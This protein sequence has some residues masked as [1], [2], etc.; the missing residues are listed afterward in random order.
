MWPSLTDISFTKGR[1]ATD[2]DVNA[3]AAVFVLKVDDVAVGL[4][5]KIEL[6]QYAYHKDTETNE[7][8]KVIVIQ[9][10]E[11]QGQSYIG[12]ITAA[13]DQYLVGFANEF[14]LLGKE[15]PRD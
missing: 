7:K 15:V 2:A 3:G 13:K 1:A 4:P 12:A 9:A 8:V 10:E 5:L 11:T 6:P 14:E